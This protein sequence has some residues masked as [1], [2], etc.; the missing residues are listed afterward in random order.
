VITAVLLPHGDDL[1]PSRVTLD[2]RTI[3]SH[4]SYLHGGYIEAIYPPDAVLY[5]VDDSRGRKDLRVNYLAT[6]IGRSI[7][8]NMAGDVIMGNALLVGR[9]DDEG[10]DTDVPEG[11]LHAYGLL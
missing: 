11:I 7:G 6:A 10:Y 8:V 9:P 2:P 3:E 5:I 1:E 4:Y